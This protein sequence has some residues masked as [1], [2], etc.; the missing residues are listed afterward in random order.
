MDRFQH[1]YRIQTARAVWHNYEGGIYFITLCTAGRIHYFGEIADGKMELSEIG[2]VAE[3]NITRISLHYPDAEIPLFVIMPNHIHAVVCIDSVAEMR[4]A[5]PLQGSEPDRKT[6][7]D[8]AMRKGRLSVVIG[9]LKSAI[10]RH[11]RLKGFPLRW[12]PRFYDRIIRNPEEMNRIA[13]YIHNNVARW[14]SD[15]YFPSALM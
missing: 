1:K 5:D 15:P 11:A 14:D 2:V 4:P 13:E 7:K 12:Q 6:M 3:R 10:S 8:M 9:G